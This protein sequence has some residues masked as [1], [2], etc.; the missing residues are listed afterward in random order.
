MLEAAVQT[1]KPLLIIA[2]DVEGEAL[3][4]LVVNKLRGGLKVAAVKA[5]ARATSRS[6]RSS[7]TS[8]T[9]PRRSPRTMRSGWHFC[10]CPGPPRNGQLSTTN[11]ATW[12]L[13]DEISPVFQTF[14][15]GTYLRQHGVDGNENLLV[16]VTPVAGNTPPARRRRRPSSLA[17]RFQTVPP[18]SLKACRSFRRADLCA[19]GC[20][21]HCLQSCKSGPSRTV[22]RASPRGPPLSVRA[23]IHATRLVHVIARKISPV[24][25]S[26]SGTRPDPEPNRRRQQWLPR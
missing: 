16:D 14:L 18:R 19:H 2:E 21:Q 7:K 23:V 3:A 15:F 4:I 1:L 11:R 25:P 9:I 8:N 13:A 17:G 24:S 26:M 10:C 20:R 6:R 5:H 22:P 12:A